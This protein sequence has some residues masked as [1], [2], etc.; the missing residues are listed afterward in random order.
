MHLYPCAQE[1]QVAFGDE[2]CRFCQL[3][4]R[5]HALDAFDDTRRSCRA[6]L[7]KHNERRK[8]KVEREIAKPK[9]RKAAPKQQRKARSASPSDSLP[10]LTATDSSLDSQEQ[11]Q[12]APFFLD[13]DTLRRE[14]DLH[15]LVLSDDIPVSATANSPLDLVRLDVPMAGMCLLSAP[16]VCFTGPDYGVEAACSSPECGPC[17]SSEGMDTDSEDAEIM[18]LWREWRD[19]AHSKPA[20]ANPLAS[21]MQPFTND[22]LSSVWQ[23]ANFVPSLDQ[24]IHAARHDARHA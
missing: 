20:K 11:E 6:R 3:C 16:D 14:L 1:E 15:S 22:L 12:Q 5:F 24:L 10:M 8:Q 21:L 23:H 4:G 17:L 19:E 18:E 7:N 13:N 9:Q 2:L